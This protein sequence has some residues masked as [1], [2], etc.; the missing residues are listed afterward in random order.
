MKNLDGLI[1]EGQG[2][3]VR[4]AL[5]LRFG[6]FDK[7]SG[8]PFHAKPGGF[9]DRA[10]AARAG[11]ML[12]IHRCRNVLVRNLQL[13]GNSGALVLGGY[14]GDVGRQL[15]A[16]GI[17]LYHNTEVGVENVHSHHHALDGI[18]IGWTGLRENDPPTP[19]TLINLVSEYNGRQG[20]SWVGGRGIRA[21]RCKFNH[22]ARGALARPPGAGLDIEAEESVCRDGYFEDC[23]FADN[24]GCGMVADSGD[25]GYTKFVRCTFWGTTAWSAWNRKPGLEYEDCMFHGSIVHAFGSPDARLATRWTRCT[26]DDKPWTD[27]KRPYGGFLAEINGDME[28]V[29]FDGCTFTAGACKSLWCSGKGVRFSDCTITHKASLV[30]NGD[31]QCLIRGGELVG[32]RFQELFPSEVKASW[33][34]AAEGTRI[35]EGKPTTVDG[36]RVRWGH[37]NGAVGLIPPGK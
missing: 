30:R 13:D 5:G 14:F 19:H 31:F 2:A 18:I 6:A 28:N 35:V 1:I 29:R 10:Y 24:G 32:C 17:E 27:G 26:F 15:H 3:T 11:S 22:T 34:V 12:R 9:T 37:L 8:K 16:Y 25:G 23:E 21:Y 4:L 33:Y 20:L 36:P 7:L